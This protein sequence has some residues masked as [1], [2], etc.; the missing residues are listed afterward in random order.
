MK[1]KTIP[2]AC[3]ALAKRYPDKFKYEKDS[4]LAGGTHYLINLE[5]DGVRQC[6]SPPEIGFM[7]EVLSVIGYTMEPCRDQ[8]YVKK[9]LIWYYGRYFWDDSIMFDWVYNESGRERFSS[10]EQTFAPTFLTAI[11]HSLENS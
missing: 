8:D 3:Q 2:E 6:I 10:P 9:H 7:Y 4:L 11:N 5:T 1:Y